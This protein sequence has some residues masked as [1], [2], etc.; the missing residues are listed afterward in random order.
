[1]AKAYATIVTIVIFRVPNA[2][3]NI[4]EQEDENL[5]DTTPDTP[6]ELVQEDLPQISLYAILGHKAQ[7]HYVLAV[8]TKSDCYNTN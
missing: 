1:M 7:R 3:V 8:N 5:P 6:D 4:L 2:K